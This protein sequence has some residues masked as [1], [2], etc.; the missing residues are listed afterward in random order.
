MKDKNLVSILETRSRGAEYTTASPA[1]DDDPPEKLDGGM[2]KAMQEDANIGIEAFN[3]KRTLELNLFNTIA[4]FSSLLFIVAAILAIMVIQKENADW[5]VFLMATAFT[6][7]PT[8]MIIAA[9]RGIYGKHEK[10]IK[11]EMP[12]ISMV[13]EIGTVVKDCFVTIKSASK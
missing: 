7:P 2:T 5:H 3:H 12:V 4:T 9:V 13:K 11:N 10:E 6:V 8:V 1:F